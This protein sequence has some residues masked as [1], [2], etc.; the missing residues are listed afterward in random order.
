MQINELSR[1]QKAVS[2]SREDSLIE[3]T[4]PFGDGVLTVS[5]EEAKLCGMEGN[6]RINGQIYAGPV[7]LVNDDGNGDFCG[8]TDKQI[9]E[10]TERFRRPED[11]SQEDVQSDTGFTFYTW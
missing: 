8:L 9:A 7:F 10:Y 11:I 4:A 5:N 3:V 1:W 6:R 2:R